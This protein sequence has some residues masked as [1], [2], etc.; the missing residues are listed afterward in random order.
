[1]WLGTLDDLAVQVPV[2]ECE[3]APSA[4]RP[5]GR[6][7]VYGMG[8]RAGMRPA[9]MKAKTSEVLYRIVCPLLV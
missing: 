5:A 3:R 9:S 6:A 1:M 7:R 8:S 4:R 2:S